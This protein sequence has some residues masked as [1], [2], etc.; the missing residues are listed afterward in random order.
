MN[1]L[2]FAEMVQRPSPNLPQAAL[3]M[4]K[5][6]AYPQLDIAHYVHQLD[7]L[8]ER[9][10]KRVRPGDSTAVRAELLSEF[11]FKEEQFVGNTAVY[12]DPR[13]SYLNDV[14]DRRLGI[15]ITLSLLYLAIADR[16]HLPAF[17]VGLPGHFIVGVAVQGDTL[18]FDPFHGGGR[19]SAADCARLVELTV[20][21]TGAFQA[22]WLTAVSPHDILARMLNNLRIIFT[23]RH[24]WPEAIAVVKRMHQ[25]QPDNPHHLRELGVMYYQVGQMRQAASYL[26]A[27]LH[28]E[29]NASDAQTIRQGI[30]DALN[31]WARQ[32]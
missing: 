5:E 26:D 25:I 10:A 27:Y 14:L 1:T 20:G 32:N 19:L 30:A 22:E 29:P 16:L 4:A 17:G 24:Q 21:Y 2:T 8:A 31:K 12:D 11:L 13:N 18:F 23:Q 9:A 15:P 3:R 6:L 28:K 7:D